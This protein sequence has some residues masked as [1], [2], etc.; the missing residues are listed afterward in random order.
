MRKF[1]RDE[2]ALSTKMNEK[3]IVLTLTNI[4]RNTKK[5]MKNRRNKT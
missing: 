1:T 5:R 4:E 2:K 3:L